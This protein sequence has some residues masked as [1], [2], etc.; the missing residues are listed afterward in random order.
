MFKK[1]LFSGLCAVAL[2]Q[3]AIANDS[4]DLKITAQLTLGSCT[5]TL[6]NGNE[7]NFGNIALGSLS[8]TGTNQLGFRY[9]TLTITCTEATALGW[10]IADNK[11]DSLQVLMIKDPKYNGEDL[12]SVDY[13]Y[14]LG[15]TAG[16]VNIG[17]YAI[18]TDIDNVTG[19]GIKLKPMY[20][21]SREMTWAKSGA[22]EIRNDPAY[23]Y[24][25][26][27]DGASDS[28]VVAAKVFVWP[29]KITA[30]IQGTETLSITDDTDLS[31]SSTISLVYL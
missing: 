19:D 13:E 24:A 12:N 2:I 4:V 8:T 6:S 30:A 7:A 1:I 27:A 31:G 26:E 20:Q 22:G 16:G 11:K 5:P 15:K 14:G 29:L 21:G 9:L 10:S 3:G 18:Y 25:A 28:V 23:I 17:A